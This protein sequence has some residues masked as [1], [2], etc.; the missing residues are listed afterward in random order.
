MKGG[1]HSIFN[2][3]FARASERRIC[4]FAISFCLL[5]KVSLAV[6]EPRSFYI[7]SR[8]VLRQLRRAVRFLFC[9]FSWVSQDGYTPFSSFAVFTVSR[10]IIDYW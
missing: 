10:S 4:F 5:G 1:T 6:R 2:G 9:F 8:G 3:D 7:V